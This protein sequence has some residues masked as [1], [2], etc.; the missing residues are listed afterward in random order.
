MSLREK[1]S[2]DLEH[3]YDETK[4]VASEVKQNASKEGSWTGSLWGGL[5]AGA[6]ILALYRWLTD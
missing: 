6:V 3:L 4:R 2:A 5:V 1:I